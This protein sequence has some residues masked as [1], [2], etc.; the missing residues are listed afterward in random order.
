MADATRPAGTVSLTE[1]TP[2]V[3]APPLLVTVMAQVLPVSLVSANV[4]LG[5]LSYPAQVEI[6][7]SS[8]QEVI[9]A[10]GPG[11]QVSQ[12][13]LDGLLNW[14]VKIYYPKSPA[15]R[16]GIRACLQTLA[17]CGV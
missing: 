12:H 16:S 6:C 13:A 11:G 10:C 4:R 14:K 9:P 1:T 15:R 7:R 2:L 5:N 17:D 3:T 8:G